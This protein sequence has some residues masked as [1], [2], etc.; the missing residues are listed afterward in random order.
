MNILKG[1]I[2]D[3]FNKNIYFG[4][5]TI[6][7]DKIKSIQ[8]LGEEQSGFSYF[9][10][11]F[12]DAHVHIESSLL[13][14]SQFGRMAVV[15]GTVA[16]VSDPHEIANVCGMDGVNFMIEDGKRIPF[17]FFFGAPS[18]VPA[19]I[20]ETAG[21]EITV[22]DIDQL[23]ANPEITYL[24]EMMNFPGVIYED[25]LVL[26]KLEIA[27]KYGKPIDGHAPRLMGKDAEKYFSKGI[28]TDHECFM[29][30]EAQEKLDLGVNILIREGSAAKNFES[31]IPLAIEN[32][33]QMMFCSDDKHPDQLLEGHI[34]QLV[35]RAIASGVDRFDALRMA[36]VNPITHY[37]L[38]VGL[39]RQGDPADFIICDNLE[40]LNILS[41]YI[42]GQKVAENGNSLIESSPSK[43]INSFSTEIIKAE[44]LQLK[45]SDKVRIIEALDGQLITREFIGDPNDQDV[46]KIVVYNR[47]HQAKPAI[48]YIKGFGIKVGALASSVAHDSHNIVAV[49][50]TD[51]DLAEAI[52][53]IVKKKGGLSAVSSKEKMTLPLPIAGLMTHKDGYETAHQ[54]IAIDGFAKSE[55]GSTLSSPFM[56]LSFM[57]LLVIPSLKLSDLGL[58]DGNRFEFV[59]IDFK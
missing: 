18:C 47:Y 23:L 39:L 24:A 4:E 49:G 55:L 3:L 41:T 56:T 29:L 58:F 7:G 20:F 37:K 59:G 31:L 43:I 19:T 45:T 25:P 48:A 54:Y 46:H 34:N 51:E 13:S 28:S 17:K 6:E 53:L 15:H 35:E 12:V 44:D 11:G 2:V 32:A 50:Q 38:P 26:K 9:L 5:I 14:P 33:D 1:N 36:S 16:T 30:E 40:N 57:A 10:P 8:N 21:A 22:D 42:D 27:R 52:N